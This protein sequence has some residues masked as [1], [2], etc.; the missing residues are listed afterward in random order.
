M[1]RST[2]QCDQRVPEMFTNSLVPLTAS[3]RG[4]NPENFAKNSGGLKRASDQ[5]ESSEQSDEIL[6]ELGVLNFGRESG[7]FFRQIGERVGRAPFCGKLP[8][9]GAIV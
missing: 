6:V 1:L 2:I 8:T 3:F 9:D 7:V 4:K 5:N